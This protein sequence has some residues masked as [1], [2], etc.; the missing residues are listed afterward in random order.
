[1]TLEVY[2]AHRVMEN[3]TVEMAVD[4]MSGG[5]EQ[6]RNGY[7]AHLVGGEPL[8]GSSTA[9]APQKVADVAMN[10]DTQLLRYSVQHP[11]MRM[12]FTVTRGHYELL[13]RRSS[14][15]S[16]PADLRGKRI[17][18]FPRTSSEYFL[19]DELGHYGIAPSEVEIVHLTPE[20][21]VS[22]ALIDGELDAVSIWEPAMQHA[23]EGVGDDGIS[24]T[25]P[26]S[27]FLRLNCNTTTEKLHDPE[28]RAEIVT[29]IQHVVRASTLIREQPEIGAGFLARAS[30]FDPGLVLRCMQTLE[31]VA[32]LEADQL[33]VLVEQEEWVAREQ[34]REPRSRDELATLIDTSVYEEAVDSLR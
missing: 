7:I 11:D 27:Y 1:M 9:G 25:R 4:A 17:G 29:F 31:F 32:H 2:G 23:K 16:A 18:T 10:A 6:M 21:A 34:H 5:Q 26:A 12:L 30:G 8:V 13:G 19:I 22:R 28:K 24:F 14:G 33:D 20:L 3:A 15:I